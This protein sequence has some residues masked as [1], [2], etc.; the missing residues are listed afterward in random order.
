MSTAAPPDVSVI[1]VSWNG[2]QHLDQCLAA[3][4][5]QEGIGFETLLVDNGSADGTAEYV[6]ARYPGVRLLTL[7]E[8]RGYAGGNNA[9]AREARGRYLALLNNDTAAD[10]GW[11]RA[12]RGGI[13]EDA[14]FCLTTS[15]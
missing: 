7:G 6:R 4:A 5:V 3:V 15:R 8:N 14:R 1:V 9:G 13:D 2:R 11:L 10:P 12:L